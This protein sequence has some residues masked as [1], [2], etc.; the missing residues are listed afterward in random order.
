V[1]AASDRLTRAEAAWRE[2]EGAGLSVEG[3]KDTTPWGLLSWA[4]STGLLLVLN[5]RRRR[6]AKAVLEETKRESREVVARQDE[7]PFVGSGG[8]L[9]PEERLANAPTRLDALE[10][11]LRSAGVLKGA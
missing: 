9:E 4:L 5:E 11:A 6:E 3:P 10:A 2:A 7:A 8:R 1:A